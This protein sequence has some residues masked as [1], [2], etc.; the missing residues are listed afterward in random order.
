MSNDRCA[1]RL[2]GWWFS[3]TQTA[4]DPVRWIVGAQA[5]ISRNADLAPACVAGL[6]LT[7]E[8]EG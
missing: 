8:T 1:R 2:A 5:A 7:R 3:L 4:A 6:V